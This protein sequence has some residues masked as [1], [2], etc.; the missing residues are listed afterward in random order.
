MEEF[1]QGQGNGGTLKF[2]S[3]CHQT[4]CQVPDCLALEQCWKLD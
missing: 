2:F 3:I 1:D 4:T